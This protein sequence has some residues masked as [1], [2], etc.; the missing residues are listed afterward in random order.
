MK[1]I[2]IFKAAIISMALVAF[3]ACDEVKT[4]EKFSIAYTESSVTIAKR[5]KHFYH[6]V[7]RKLQPNEIQYRS[8]GKKDRTKSF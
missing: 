1:K 4:Y 8:N 5:F 7:L 2:L 3:T 6:R